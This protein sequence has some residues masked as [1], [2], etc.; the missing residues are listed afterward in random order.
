MAADKEINKRIFVKGFPRE[1]TE[2]DLKTF[3][4]GQACEYR[5]RS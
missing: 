5:K 2:N 1:T 4:D 3:F